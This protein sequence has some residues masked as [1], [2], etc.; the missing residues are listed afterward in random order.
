MAATIEKSKQMERNPRKTTLRKT[1][2]VS[3][4][5]DDLINPNEDSNLPGWGCFRIDHDLWSY[6]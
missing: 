5:A 4:T 3:L 2:G 1:A 6:S